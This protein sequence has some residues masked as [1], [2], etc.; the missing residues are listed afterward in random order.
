MSTVSR[1][2]PRIVHADDVK[3]RRVHVAGREMHYVCGATAVEDLHCQEFRLSRLPRRNFFMYPEERSGPE[4]NSASMMCEHIDGVF[5]QIRLCMRSARQGTSS[6]S[7][8]MPFSVS[9]YEFWK[10]CKIIVLVNFI[11]DSELFFSN[12]PRKLLELQIK[13]THSTTVTVAKEK[14]CD[15]TFC[16][17]TNK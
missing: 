3:N 15:A 13:V 1:D 11:C 14:R 8:H 10:V 9:F 5:S 2:V 16:L 6:A 12:C 7:F 4:S 17:R